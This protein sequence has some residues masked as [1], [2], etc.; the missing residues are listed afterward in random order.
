MIGIT[1]AKDDE[2]EEPKG[3]LILTQGIPKIDTSRWSKGES[4]KEEEEEKRRCIVLK[5]DKNKRPGTSVVY[6]IGSICRRC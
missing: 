2:E 6:G 5:R 3:L 1:E 4:V